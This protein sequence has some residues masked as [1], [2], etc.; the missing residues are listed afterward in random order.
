MG[1]GEWAALAAALFW[2]LSSLLWGKIRVS[3]I[4]LNIC[5]N[6]LAAAMIGIHLFVLH[7]VV[8]KPILLMSTASLGWLAT[9]GLIGIVIGD[10]LYFRSIQILGARK[11]L[12][13]ATTSPLFAAVLAWCLLNER[14]QVIGIVGIAL[15]VF[16]VVVVVADR[17]AN[18]E[19]PGLFPGNASTGIC[20]GLLAAVCQAVG[21]VFSKK[22][23]IDC[24]AL[25]ATLIRISVAALVT[26][27]IVIW[28]GQ[29]RRLTQQVFQKDV[30]KYLIP[31]TALGTWLGIWLSQIA[32]KQASE[33]AIAQ[34]LMATCPLFAI[35]IVIFVYRHNVSLLAW[36]G[37]L[38]AI[39]GIFLAVK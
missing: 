33:V 16:G 35:P 25:D 37:T 4:G 2:T 34:T 26:L 21:A 24:D 8:H 14:L 28:Q 27:G 38:V 18:I 17:Q 22:G 19:V 11:A 7:L 13:M 5:K 10:T 36:L 12:M 30:I 23:M 32:F 39:V 9:S 6:F 15:T 29:L 31:A 1:I 20:F 3:A